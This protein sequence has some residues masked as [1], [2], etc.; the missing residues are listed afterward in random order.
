MTVNNKKLVIMRGLPGSGKS[1]VAKKLVGNGVIHSTDNYFVNGGAYKFDEQNILRF[2]NLNLMDSIES[3]KNGV[4]PIIIDNTNIIS[5]HCKS[6]VEEAKIYGYDV[7]VVEPCAEWA[8]DIEELI[9]RNV[10]DVPRD[11]IERMLEIYEDHDVFK[12][13]LGL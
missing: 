3:M 5:S 13:K 8:F 7:V 1:H 9:K 11:V 12:K 10:H 2:H 6:Y 4:S